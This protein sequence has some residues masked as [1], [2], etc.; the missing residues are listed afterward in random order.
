MRH[1]ILFVKHR[2]AYPRAS[3]HDIRCF[4]MLRALHAL[5]HDMALATV[6]PV[7]EPTR[8]QL[9]VPWFSLTDAAGGPTKVA[10]PL[11]YLQERFRS[12]WGVSPQT[13]EA[14][15]RT[16]A[17]F[18]A[19]VVVGLGLEVLPFLAGARDCV[20]VWY[21][22]DEWVL[23]YLSLIRLTDPHTYS[24]LR[25]AVIHGLYERAY[26]PAID[27]AWVVSPKEQRAM[28]RFA[29]V[30][31]VDVVPNGVDTAYF[32]LTAAAPVSNSAVFWGRLDFGPNLQALDWFC[33]RIWP[34]VRERVPSAQ[35]TIMGF[36]AAPE[37]L[38][39][40]G[41]DG[42]T[43]LTDVADI[44]PTVAAHQIALLPMISGGGIKNKLLEAAA[45]AKAIICTT[46]ACS[47]LR[48]TPPATVVDDE[49]G[50][51]EAIVRLWQRDDE[52]RA[53][54]QS[55]RAWILEHHTWEAAARDVLRGLDASLAGRP[56]TGVTLSATA[57]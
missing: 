25:A 14:V 3:G 2:Q 55:A 30:R 56:R 19:T 41:R 22:A 21:A 42:I 5:G 54:E 12:Y 35:L 9:G 4:E 24:D 33:G 51:V 27:R 6:E 46:K 50:W 11:T 1:R 20:K 17:Q 32:A 26:A 38:A 44:R 53:L 18:E 48:G 47:G 13:V 40:A 28:R 36:N 39:R 49:R 34:G 23:H 15:A 45:L 10:M 29:G 7:H 43:V 16:A 52:R 57:G 37:V 31:N 8:D